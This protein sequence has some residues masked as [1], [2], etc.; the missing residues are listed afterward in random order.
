[1]VVVD[2]SGVSDA[3]ADAAVDRVETSNRSDPVTEDVDASTSP[4]AALSRKPNNDKET[5]DGTGKGDKGEGESKMAVIRVPMESLNP[6][7]YCLTAVSGSFPSKKVDA[8][9]R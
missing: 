9:C 3:P 4:A 1:M 6:A 7:M 8:P 5:V 2:S